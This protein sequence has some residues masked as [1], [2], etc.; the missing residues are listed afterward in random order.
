M[1]RVYTGK[2]KGKTT[3]A[4]GEALLARGRGVEV[5]IIQFL[6]GSTYM[7]ELYGLGRLGIPIIQFGI[8]CRWSAMIR[9][10]LR[11]CTGCGECFRQNRDPNIALPLVAQGVEFLKEQIRNP[12]LSL[13]ILDEVSHALNKGFLELEVLIEIMGQ[14]PDDLDWIL[15]GRDMPTDLTNIVDEW[16][17]LQPEKH[18]FQ[19]GI[20]SRRGIEY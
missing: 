19:A 11:H 9:T 2:G 15:T 10:G 5:L 14:R 4:L 12:H 8:G 6:K 18:P 1:I 20:R 16:W 3:S 13:V 7:G 17:E